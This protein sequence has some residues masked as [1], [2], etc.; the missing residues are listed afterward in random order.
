M[1][2]VSYGIVVISAGVLYTVPAPKCFIQCPDLTGSASTAPQLNAYH[3]PASL[4][5]TPNTTATF[6]CTGSYIVVGAIS[7]TCQYNGVW[8]A[9][10][11][12]T[13]PGM[14]GSQKNPT[15]MYLPET[16]QKM[17]A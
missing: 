1:V 7:A 16:V 2:F 15:C 6:N 9:P 14:L 13:L 3:T 4:K 12:S 8:L 10:D 17:L 5:R 11:G